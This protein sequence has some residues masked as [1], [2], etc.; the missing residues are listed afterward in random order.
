MLLVDANDAVAAPVGGAWGLW[1]DWVERGVA[2]GAAELLSEA[3]AEA[4][5]GDLES[6][7]E[8]LD[9]ALLHFPSDPALLKARG[10]VFA[11]MGFTRA[12]ELEFERAAWL[13]PSC[14]G[15]WWALG[16][17]RLALGLSMSAVEAFEHARMLGGDDAEL[18]LLLARAYEDTGELSDAGRHY[19][20]AMAL[21]PGAP[22]DLLLEAASVVARIGEPTRVQSRAALGWLERAEELAPDDVR[23]VLCRGRIHEQL[24]ELEEAA[25][26]YEAALE[27]DHECG[28]ALLHLALVSFEAGDDARGAEALAL[29]LAL[30]P[31]SERRELLQTL[32]PERTAGED[33][34]DR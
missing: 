14:A 25:Q 8:T 23:V 2:P 33:G 3:R 22:A 27:I 32:F 28:A 12:A 29:A 30:E 19:T 6:A 13:D 17:M 1:G 20:D 26:A 24:D 7:T 31:D 5:V 11:E 4:R 21:D 15:V 9:E 34:R 10:V 18:A 16:T